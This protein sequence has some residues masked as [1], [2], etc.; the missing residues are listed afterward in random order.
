MQ[1]RSSS[2][3]SWPA[4]TTMPPAAINVA[5]LPLDLR[6]ELV[7]E[8]LV[9]LVEEQ[10]RRPDPLRNRQPDLRAHPLRVRADGSLERV[11]EAALDLDL[12]DHR[13]RG[14][15]PEAVEHCRAARRSPDRSALPSARPR[16]RAAC[17][18]SP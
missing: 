15:K 11:S 18:S 13:P 1:M 5:R 7:V 14:P 12:V 9:H 3:W 17:R 6:A 16:S 8:R 4:A 2:G 10:H